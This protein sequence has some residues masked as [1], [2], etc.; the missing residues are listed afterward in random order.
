MNIQ[1]WFPLGLTGLISLPS[2]GLSKV[3]SNTTIQ[4]HEFSGAQPSLWG[5]RNHIPSGH[6][7]CWGWGMA[8]K[9]GTKDRYM[10]YVTGWGRD[11]LKYM[12]RD[13]EA[14]QDKETKKKIM[15]LG[16]KPSWYTEGQG[17]CCKRRWPQEQGGPLICHTGSDQEE[18]GRKSKHCKA[19][20]RAC[21]KIAWAGGDI[22]QRKELVDQEGIRF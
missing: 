13:T 2:K 15:T 16:E 8:F 5:G 9:L 21:C 20:W 17:V 4:K 19:S 11:C 1:N 22:L 3:F 6:W 7:Q 18:W 12:I 14:K 10:Q